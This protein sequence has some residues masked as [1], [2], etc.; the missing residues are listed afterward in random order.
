MTMNSKRSLKGRKEAHSHSHEKKD[1]HHDEP[2]TNVIHALMWPVLP[3]DPSYSSL[4]P[5][6][7]ASLWGFS[8]TLLS[9]SVTQPSHQPGIGREADTKSLRQ[10]GGQVVPISRAV[11]KSENRRGWGCRVICARNRS[12]RDVESQGKAHILQ[13]L[14]SQRP[15]VP[16]SR[17]SDWL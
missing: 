2:S 14:S 7:G 6:R 10:L 11:L 13:G 16:G 3:Q 17:C 8:K 12:V 1:N 15:E 4:R 9:S 5:S